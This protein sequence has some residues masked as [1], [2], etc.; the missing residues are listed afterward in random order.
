MSARRALAL[1]SIH[2]R[3]VPRP[4]N[5]S[6]SREIFRVLQGFG[7]ISTYQSL[8]YEYQNPADNVAFAIY[9][10]ESSAQ[11]ALDASPIRFALETSTATED[12]TSTESHYTGEE[13]Q[14]DA[15]TDHMPQKAGIDEIL[16]PSQLLNRTSAETHRSTPSAPPKPMPFDPPPVSPKQKKWTKW[17]QVTVDRTRAVHQDFI[18]RQP[19]WKQFS[20]M[21]S[22]AQADLEKKVPHIGLSDISKRPP[23]AYRTPTRV[24]KTM[25]Q[26]VET[27]MPTLRGVAEGSENERA[28]LERQERRV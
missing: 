3:I 11:S 18:E 2:L 9:R 13:D 1:R 14:E 28:Y 12:N 4:A 26:Y 8:R 22:M 5:L 23:N 10:H 21:R 15:S 24:L 17:F 27:A 19:Y 16:R 6:E 20:P 25:N 7:E